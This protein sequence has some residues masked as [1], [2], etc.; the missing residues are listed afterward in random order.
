MQTQVSTDSAA[1]GVLRPFSMRKNP[2]LAEF[3]TI[4]KMAAQRIAP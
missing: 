1:A 4:A 2:L 3:T